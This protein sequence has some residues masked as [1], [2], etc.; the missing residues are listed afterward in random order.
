M[1][2]LV[3]GAPYQGDGGA[4]YIYHGSTTGLSEDHVQV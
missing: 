4:V 1:L 3:I 2:D